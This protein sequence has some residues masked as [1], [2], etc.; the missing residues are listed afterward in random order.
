MSENLAIDDP[1]DADDSAPT[2][3]KA[4]RRECLDCN[5][6]SNEVKLCPCKPRRELP[7]C[8][9]WP[10]RFGRRPDAATL[11]EYQEAPRPRS[12]A[13]MSP[14][15]ALQDIRVKCLDCSG[16]SAHEVA[17]CKFTA[18]NLFPF[19]FGT[20]P[21]IERKEYTP[22][23]RA[24]FAERLARNLGRTGRGGSAA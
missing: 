12:P 6:T 21:N 19:R 5:K 17:N 14:G 9:L 24:A 2:P 18:C 13:P 3:L 16:G 20:N 1:D 11:A 7:G 22:E 23:Q 8:A 4:L 10:H 15:S